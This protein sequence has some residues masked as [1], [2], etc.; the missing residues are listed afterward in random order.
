MTHYSNCT[1]CAVDKSACRRRKELADAL[2]GLSVYSLKFRCTDRQSMFSPGQRVVF[3]W[4]LW[5]SDG[6]DSDALPLIFKGTVLCERGTKFVVQV[7][8]G[9][10]ASGEGIEAKDVFKKNDQLLVKVRPAHM[11]PL[12]EP[13]K[14]ICGT[15]Y[16]VEGVAED[17]CYQSGYGHIP[18]GCINRLAG[19]KPESEAA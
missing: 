19:N 15:C 6:Y 5:D 17:R 4:V 3:D 14:L 1:N 13:S 11:R 10:D 9:V 8:H 7:D 2:K 18:V 16:W 12:D